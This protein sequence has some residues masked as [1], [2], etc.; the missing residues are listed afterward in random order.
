MTSV[1][2]SLHHG[3]FPSHAGASPRRFLIRS[4]M[5]FTTPPAKSS[6]VY[7]YEELASTPRKLDFSINE[8]DRISHPSPVVQVNII[9]NATSPPNHISKQYSSVKKQL[10]QR[11]I[12]EDIPRFFFA[13]HWSGET[14]TDSVT[15][16]Q[17][18][19][20]E[21]VILV[22][23]ILVPFTTVVVRSFRPQA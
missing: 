16:D 13:L 7:P 4:D 21:I 14:M 3:P 8:V 15:G 1:A 18:A 2:A 20:W 19:V 12:D 6:I 5:G 17:S 9:L 10:A 23:Q 11:L 22:A